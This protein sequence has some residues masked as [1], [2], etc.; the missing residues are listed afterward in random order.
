MQGVRLHDLR[1]GAAVAWLSAGVPVVQVSR[2]LGTRN[3]RSHLM[4]TATG[5]LRPPIIRYPSRRRSTLLCRF[6]A[7]VVK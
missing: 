4:S 2:W 1:H 6:A 5:Y 3:Q 7:T